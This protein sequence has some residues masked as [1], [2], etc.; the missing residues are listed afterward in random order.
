[1]K[2]FFLFFRRKGVLLFL[3]GFLVAVLIIFS[4]HKAVKVTGTDEFCN[5]C[6]KVHPHSTTSWK[7]ST[8]Y[9]NKR[10]I[11]VHCVECHLP[12][13]GLYKFTEKV[14]TGMRDVYGVVFK[15]V[16]KINW[17]MKS[18]LDHA[19][20]HTYEES[21]IACHENL[22][23]MGLTKEGEDAHL[24][25]DDH[26]DE[27][28]CIN[29]HLAVGHYSET[30]IHA[31]NVDFGKVKAEVDTIY[32]E[33]AVIAAFEDFTETVPGTGL[34]F[35]MKAIPGGSFAIGSPEGEPFR[36]DDEGPSVEVSVSDF[37]M[38]ELEVGWDLYL[39]F[40]SETESEGRVSQEELALRNVDGITGPTPPWG[41]PS[42]GWGKEKRPA[43]TMSHHAATVFCEWLSM[44][45]GKNYRLPTEA[46]WEYAAR[47]GTQGA[48][49]FEGSP[50][51]YTSEGF[52]KKIF[53]RDTT[54]INTF[55]IYTENSM[56]RSQLPDAVAPNPFGLKHMLGNVAEFCSDYYRQ[57]VYNTY[58]DGIKDPT[59][60]ESGEEFV[61]RGGSFNADASDIRVADRD[62]TRTTAWLKTDP[63]MPKSIWWYSDA[64]HVGFRIVCDYEEK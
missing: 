20:H 58:A 19:V 5:S 56:G 43:I 22:Y 28:H 50:K 63:Q 29:C 42:Q 33:P 48:Y 25:Y 2:R 18:T 39:T 45:T 49:F 61:V 35:H 13:G 53:G 41:D 54:I 32:A 46:E 55:A 11:A 16:S 40:F 30:N 24:H 62:Y 52:W 36:D 9:D 21:C 1:M 44:R 10:G 14:K 17:E 37:F 15:D 59:G 60:P 26:R 23:P 31:K 57:D 64:I 6:H 7:M 38:A 12:P 47:G 34:S 51:D 27:L 4:G 3:A 8:H